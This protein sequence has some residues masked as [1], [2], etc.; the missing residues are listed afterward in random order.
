MK[1][2]KTTVVVF[3]LLAICLSLCACKDDTKPVCVSEEDGGIWNYTVNDDDTITIVGVNKYSDEMTVPETLD[4]KVVSALDEKCFVIIDDG[5]DK[6]VY[7]ENTYL[8][9]LTINAKIK[10]IPLMCCYYCTKLE[11]V[12]FPDTLETV[13]AFSFFLCSSLT[14]VSFPASVISIEEY[15]FR[16]CLSLKDVYIYNNGDEVIAIGDKAFYNLDE[17]APKNKQYYISS[18]LSIYVTN[19]GLFNKDRLEEK[20]VATKDYTYKYWQEYLEAGVIKNME[21]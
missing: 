20:R 13:E 17:K 21:A 14:S 4:G 8:K 1:F 3:L 19:I 5:S 11:S 18:D 16:Q 15:S 6:G 7:R 9:K 12:V 2:V 10:K